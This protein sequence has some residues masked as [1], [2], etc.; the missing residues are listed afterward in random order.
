MAVKKMSINV[1]MYGYKADSPIDVD[2]DADIEPSDC[3]SS[4]SL[5]IVIL[6]SQAEICLEIPE[7]P[8]WLWQYL[9]SQSQDWGW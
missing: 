2:L 5:S 4:H 3:H 7:A 9:H 8:K 6:R 1:L